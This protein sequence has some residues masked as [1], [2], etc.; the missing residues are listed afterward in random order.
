VD[1]DQCIYTNQQV[2]VIFYVD[3][4]IILLKPQDKAYMLLFKDALIRK[5]AMREIGDM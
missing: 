5:Y 1:E 2:T 4:I 3:N